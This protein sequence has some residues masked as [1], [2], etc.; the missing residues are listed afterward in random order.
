MRGLGWKRRWRLPSGGMGWI[1]KHGS[2]LYRLSG[3]R[4]SVW[5]ACAVR[6]SGSTGDPRYGF[7][8]RHTV[9]GPLQLLVRKYRGRGCETQY[10]RL[11]R[12]SL[13]RAVCRI[14]S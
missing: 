4:M 8:Q 2:F 7:S 10:R 9:S 5:N 11:P 1:V 3:C 12:D 14:D 13:A 6:H